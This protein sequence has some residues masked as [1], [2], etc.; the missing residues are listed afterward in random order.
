MSSFIGEYKC[1][2]D[3]KSRLLIPSGFRRFIAGENAGKFMISLG[4]EKCLNLYPMEGWKKDV[5]RRLHELPR[6]MRRRKIVRFY[7]GTSRPVE[8][9]KTG[10]I[11]IPRNFLK[12]IDNAREVYVVGMLNY[13]EIWSAGDYLG[14]SEK[15]VE[16]F[17]ELDWEY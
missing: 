15:I 9:D 10:R 6:G 1:K 16:E 13:L 3:S 12:K 5:E 2:I 14:Q 11:A 7:S 17:E 4:G 8:M